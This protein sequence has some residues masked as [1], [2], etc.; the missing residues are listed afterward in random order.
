[1]N[2]DC[3]SHKHEMRI[4]DATTIYHPE[5][6]HLCYIETH[7]DCILAHPIIF[8]NKAAA[9][10]WI[11]NGTIAEL[12]EGLNHLNIGFSLISYSKR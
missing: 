12:Q 9:Q 4:S 6:G 8:K 5:H 3:H 2:W 11:D 1:M 7:Y 10:R